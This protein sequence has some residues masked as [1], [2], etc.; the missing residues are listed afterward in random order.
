MIDLYQ[1]ANEIRILLEE[2]RKELNLSF[3]EDDHI[4]FMNDNEKNSKNDWPSVSKVIKKFH[5]PFPTQE[6][7]LKKAKGD[8]ILQQKFIR[9][10][11]QMADYANNTGSKVHF[12]LEK[13][14][15]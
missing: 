7:S 3:I 12:F 13:K 14:N 8:L 2:R 10:W 6:A 4:Y 1:I 15:T 9:E 5:D 11:S